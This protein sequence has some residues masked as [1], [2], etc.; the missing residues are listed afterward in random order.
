MSDS[1][2]K[3]WLFH[4]VVQVVSTQCMLS[5]IRSATPTVFILFLFVLNDF[6]RVLCKPTKNFRA[7]RALF[8][9]LDSGKT[10]SQRGT[11]S[12]SIYKF[13]AIYMPRK[14]MV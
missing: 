12:S 4:Q 13:Y 6:I 1:Q 9:S 11:I 5:P 8:H 10:M 14:G 3:V 7:L 2:R